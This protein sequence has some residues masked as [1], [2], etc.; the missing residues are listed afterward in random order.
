MSK[1]ERPLLLNRS[2]LGLKTRPGN[3]S[4]YQVEPL[5][6]NMLLIWVTHQEWTK[7]L[8]GQSLL[9]FWI[10]IFCLYTMILNCYYWIKSL[11]NTSTAGHLGNIIGRK[12]CIP[13]YIYIEQ[14]FYYV[15]IG[16]IFGQILGKQRCF[17]QSHI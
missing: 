6:I 17:D 1:A 13:K 10:T 7:G 14:S 8:Y 15:H 9:C 3:P 5:F 4:P 16:N 2:R 12:P 11:G